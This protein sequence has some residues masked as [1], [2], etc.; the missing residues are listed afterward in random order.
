MH[1]SHPAPSPFEAFNPQVLQAMSMFA[2][3]SGMPGFASVLAIAPAP[4][5]AAAPVVGASQNI[6][7]G[8]ANAPEATIHPN[9]ELAGNLATLQREVNSLREE[10]NRKRAADNDVDGEDE[11]NLSKKNKRSK[12]QD[13]EPKRYL[14]VGSVQN[15]LPQQFSIHSELMVSY[16]HV[17]SWIKT[18]QLPQEKVGEE[19]EILAGGLNR[20]KVPLN[21]EDEPSTPAGEEPMFK[22]NF[23]ANVDDPVNKKILV[24]AAQVVTSMQNPVSDRA[25]DMVGAYLMFPRLPR[26]ASCP[27]RPSNGLTMMYSR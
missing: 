22:F 11:A 25:R 16:L 3:L 24:Q 12:K 14:T 17:Y 13:K 23:E 4:V 21:E 26:P 2:S 1:A 5:P 19:I 10:V 7:V 20:Y 6:A 9:L 15:L 8:F 27:T 18:C